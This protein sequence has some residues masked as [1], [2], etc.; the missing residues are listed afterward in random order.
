V[1]RFQEIINMR[2]FSWQGNQP[3]G[4]MIF[5]C[6]A[7][8]FFLLASQQALSAPTQKNVTTADKKQ[9]KKNQ[10]K[11]NRSPA[12]Q[13]ASHPN[14]GVVSTTDRSANRRAAYRVSQ[15]SM[16]YGQ[17]MGLHKIDDPLELKSS[18]A[19]V[20]D[21]DTGQ[22]LYEKNAHAVLPIASITKL[23]TALVVV[24]AGL[25]LDEILEITQADQDTEKGTGSRL[26]FGT[27]L[28]RA[29]ALHLALMSSE[30]RA[31]SALGRH[32][33]GGLNAFVQAMNAKAQLLGMTETFY[34]DPTGLSSRNKSSAHD[35]ARLMRF[36]YQYPLI[37]E[38]STS[39]GYSLLVDGRYYDFANTNRLIQHSDWSIGLQKTG[40]ITEAGQCLVMQATINGRSTIMVFLDAQGKFSR[41]GDANRIKQ[42]LVTQQPGRHKNITVSG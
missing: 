39:S 17:Q 29:E 42:W 11:K 7:T 3:V 12:R 4:W 37:R 14:R 6:V 1:A 18:V 41:F 5:F 23:M 26:K 24:E 9:V 16:S 32:Y 8:L 40:F 25:S 34:A 2:H 38:Y 10:I 27:R 31:A 20:L 33:P 22:V 21:Q 15:S 35:L 28:S 30:N 13:L 36:A 19:L